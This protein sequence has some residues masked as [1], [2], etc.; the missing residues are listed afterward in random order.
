MIKKVAVI[1]GGPA[2][3]C[4]VYQAL[5][6]QSEDYGFECVGFEGKS[7][8]GGVWS[9][10]PGESL[11]S[12]TVVGQ[13]AKLQDPTIAH[14][15][16]N[17][18]YDNSPLVNPADGS[19]Q[20]KTLSG[21]GN[22]KPLKISRRQSLRDGICFADKTGIY[23]DFVS[24]TPKEM[25]SFENSSIGQSN[26][27]IYPLVD[28]PSIKK[29]FHEF[30]DKNQLQSHYRMN[31]SV[32]YLDKFGPTKY[33]IVAKKSD[34]ATDYDEWYLESFDAVIIANGHFLTPYIPY[35]MSQPKDGELAA[36]TIHDFNKKFSGALV[37]LRDIDGWYHNVLPQLPEKS[38]H[39]R[40]VIVGKSFS[41]MDVLKRI[42]HL[43]DSGDYE[44][45]ISTNQKPEPD[46][47]SPFKWF[48]EWLLQT[49]R[50]TIKPQIQ[51]FDL[52]TND[53]QIKF[54]DGSHYKVDYVLFATGYLYSFP[55]ISPQ[56]LESCRITTTPDPRNED[57]QPSNVSRVTGLYLH[58]FSIAEP[59]LTFCGISSNANFQSFD[60]SAKAIVG[61][62][63]KFNKQFQLQNP[64]D[65]PHFD[66]VWSQVLPPI[67]EQLMWTQ[68]RYLKTGNS[69]AFHYYFPLELLFQEWLEPSKRIFPDGEQV[70][71]PSSWREQRK[72][73][74]ERLQKLFQNAMQTGSSH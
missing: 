40:L 70:Q 2:G 12:P 49:D 66:S 22:K 17:I 53:P 15:P 27:D 24:N 73:G 71:F 34:P 11:E 37:H 63:T 52:S 33:V 13:L 4:S 1:G 47:R 67:R 16:R 54:V 55:F 43:Q 68:E 25:M 9:D 21:T 32:E 44:I 20:L 7:K 39:R 42:Q 46:E 74:F 18:F 51:E 5:K 41:C 26:P 23:D 62:F 45:I 72:D 50:V 38:Q 29:A 10:T 8:L 48:D 31:T 3:L 60:I 35:Y 69:G 64:V 30:I 6:S 36:K 56:L 14:D 57:H 19:I 28:L 65:F 59:T 61:A 58:T